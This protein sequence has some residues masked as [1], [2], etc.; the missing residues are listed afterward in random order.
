MAIDLWWYERRKQWCADVH[1]PEGR[2]RLYLGPNE[3]KA[4]AELHR[5]MASYY[6][7]LDG[8]TADSKPRLRSS[9]GTV[10]LVELVVRFLRWT[11]AN[12]APGTWR[13][14]RDGLKH[15]TRRHKTLLADELTPLARREGQGRDDW[16]RLPGMYD[17]HHGDRHQARL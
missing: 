2:Q 14:Y 11:K 9:R 10:S 6:D 3:K 1:T 16:A 15:V 8:G 7:G 12:R 17:Q 4:R 13:G 5:Y